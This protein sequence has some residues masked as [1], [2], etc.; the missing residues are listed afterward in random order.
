MRRKIKQLTERPLFV[1]RFLL[2][3]EA[4]DVERERDARSARLTLERLRLVGRD[5]PKNGMLRRATFERRLWGTK[6]E[7]PLDGDLSEAAVITE[8]ER[9]L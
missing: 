8:A 9:E 6:E 2:E 1:T 4:P 3:R 7:D 5:E